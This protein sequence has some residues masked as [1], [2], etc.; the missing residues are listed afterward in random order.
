MPHI[1]GE[2]SRVVRNA[3]T[4]H[5]AGKRACSFL[6]GVPRYPTNEFAD[7]AMGYLIVDSRSYRS[8][9]SIP[10]RASAVRKVMFLWVLLGLS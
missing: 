7:L 1:R 9:R 3:P 8:D 6:C 4:F 10:R 5:R 2:E